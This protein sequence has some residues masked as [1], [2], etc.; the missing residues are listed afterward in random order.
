MKSLKKKAPRKIKE[1]PQALEMESFFCW[2]GDTLVFNVLGAPNSNKDQIGK[3]KGNQL[4]ISVTAVPRFGR[5]TDHMVKF[6]A[7]E[8][9]VKPTDITVVFGRFSVNKQLRIKA[10]Q[11]LPSVF[12]K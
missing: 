6:L 12:R 11:K 3:P 8:F 4:C 7:L 9:E 2:D 10:P 1:K 5:A